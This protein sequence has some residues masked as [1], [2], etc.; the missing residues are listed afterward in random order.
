MQ[1]LACITTERTSRCQTTK[2]SP[3]VLLAYEHTVVR[4][5]VYALLALVLSQHNALP[6]I[7]NVATLGGQIITG[8]NSFRV[9]SSIG[10]DLL[11]GHPGVFAGLGVYE[12][13]A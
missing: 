4:Q 6:H 2:T 9:Q 13:D 12:Q 10:E 1:N 8:L 3:C 11:L 7:A 5:L